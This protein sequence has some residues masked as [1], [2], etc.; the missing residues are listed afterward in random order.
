MPLAPTAKSVDHRY[1]SVPT[2]WPMAMASALFA[3]ETELYLQ[4]LKF[5]GEEIKI[6]ETLRPKLATPSRPR[7]DLRT[8]VLREYGVPSGLSTLVIAP[9]AGHTAMIADYH[10]GQS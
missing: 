9:Y 7:L 4:N 3:G 1:L 6:H 2:F 8:M 5:A 10:R